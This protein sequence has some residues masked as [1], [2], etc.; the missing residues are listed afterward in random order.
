MSRLASSSTQAPRISA[1][2]PPSHIF[3]VLLS[4]LRRTARRLTRSADDADDLVQD[5]VL[6][7]WARLAMSRSAA[8]SDAGPIEDL[9]AYAFATL[10]HRAFARGSIVPPAETEPEDI[11]APRGSDASLRLACAEALSALE[12]LPQDQRNLLKLRAMDG[13]SYAEIADKTGLPLGTVT[14]RMARGRAALREALDLPP[15]TPV[16]DLLGGS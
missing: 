10:R 16:N 15:G 6:R 4:D 13:L 8:S 12:E 1:S 9:R 11:A 14:S 7:V 5:T 3:G 2:L